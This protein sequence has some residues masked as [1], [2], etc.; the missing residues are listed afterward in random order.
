MVVVDDP[1]TTA[2]TVGSPSLLLSSSSHN[3]NLAVDPGQAMTSALVAFV[4]AG[5]P[6]AVPDWPKEGKVL[7]H[8]YE[9][10]VGIFLRYMFLFLLLLRGSEGEPS[11]SF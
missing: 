9:G 6:C 7:F 1:P 11:A 4:P 2:V 8:R 3:P 5:T 10:K